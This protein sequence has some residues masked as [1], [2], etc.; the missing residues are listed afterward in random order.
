MHCSNSPGSGGA[1]FSGGEQAGTAAVEAQSDRDTSEQL[2]GAAL[3]DSLCAS[4]QTRR[5]TRVP[6]SAAA[7]AEG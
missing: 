5:A 6:G 7:E 3:G 1:N 2:E 4:G